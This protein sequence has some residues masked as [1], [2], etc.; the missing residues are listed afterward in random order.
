MRIRLK[1]YCVAEVSCT[2]SE[3]FIGVCWFFEARGY[4]DRDSQFF[5]KLAKTLADVSNLFPARVSWVGSLDQIDTVYEDAVNR[6][7]R[8]KF[9]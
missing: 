4:K 5:T 9:S 1:F 7:F 6:V 2:R 3:V 8:A